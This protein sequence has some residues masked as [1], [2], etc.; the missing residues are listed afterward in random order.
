M[1]ADIQTTE[2]SRWDLDQE[3]RAIRL[4]YM[5][6]DTIAS[7]IKYLKE[8]VDGKHRANTRTRSKCSMFLMDWHD[9][10]TEFD[11]ALHSIHRKD[12]ELESKRS[13]QEIRRQEVE[14]K[15]LEIAARLEAIRNGQPQ[16]QIN[17]APGMAQIEPADYS[18]VVARIVSKSGL[19]GQQEATDGLSE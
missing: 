12:L 16:V 3:M 15:R 9:K 14:A 11:I 5:P 19:G 17:M 1:S 2:K 18:D 7:C 8:V 13:D 10:Q 4:G 6:K